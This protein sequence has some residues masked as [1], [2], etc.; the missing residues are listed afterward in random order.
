MHPQH[1]PRHARIAFLDSAAKQLRT[2]PSEAEILAL[3]RALA[4]I[5]VVGPDIGEPIPGDTV[6][7]QL[8][9]TPTKSSAYASLHWITALCTSHTSFEPRR[10]RLCH[11]SSIQELWSPRAR[12]VRTVVECPVKATV[13]REGPAQDFRKGGPARIPVPGTHRGLGGPGPRGTGST[14]AHPND[15]SSRTLACG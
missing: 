8:R 13:L 15:G 14:T 10:S 7:P 5:S 2:S 11:R 9:S 1:G 4:V 3:D 6:G 12:K